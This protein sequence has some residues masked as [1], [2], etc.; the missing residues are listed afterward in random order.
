[1]VEEKVY[2]R[3]MGEHSQRQKHVGESSVDM[4]RSHVRRRGE[5]RR[6]ERGES[7]VAA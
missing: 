2:Y 3:H 4:T 5:E 7:G 6:R 1:M